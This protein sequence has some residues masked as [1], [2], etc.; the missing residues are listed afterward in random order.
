MESLSENHGLAILSDKDR[1]IYSV[2]ISTGGLAEIRMARKN[3][4]CQIIA[5]TLDKEGAEFA[6][7]KVQEALLSQQINVRIEDV[8]KPI[9]YPNEYFDFIYARLVLHYLP[10]KRSN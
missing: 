4:K 9:P 2:G 5:T 10:K 8:A 3:P 7:K 1:R 6:R